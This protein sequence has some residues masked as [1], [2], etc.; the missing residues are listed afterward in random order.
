VTQRLRLT[1]QTWVQLQLVPL[2]ACE[3]LVV[4]SWASSQNCC[5]AP[6]Y[7]RTSELFE[8]WSQRR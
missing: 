3:S 2:W 8:Q 4:E 5:H 1:Q 6:W 7:A